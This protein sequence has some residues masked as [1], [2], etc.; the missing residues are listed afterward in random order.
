M[1]AD[2]TLLLTDNASRAGLGLIRVIV[3]KHV[4]ERL[5]IG[6]GYTLTKGNPPVGHPFVEHRAVQ[7]TNLRLLHS[8]SGITITSRTRLEAR[9][10]ERD[11]GLDFRL[12][13]QVRA[14][15]PLPSA[16]ARAVLW[17]ECFYG[18]DS[19]RWSGRT[20]PA[21]MLNFA[22]FRVPVT[23]SVAIEPGYLNQ[24]AFIRGRNRVAHVA[25]LTVS[26][27]Y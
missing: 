1:K 13:Q 21:L 14:E 16:S 9:L 7:E 2:A 26:K 5:A 15:L 17:N 18:L 20:G 19:A 12:R 24:V 27:R 23:E 10:R 4:D 3:L 11:R 8:P 25:V 6:G 22:G